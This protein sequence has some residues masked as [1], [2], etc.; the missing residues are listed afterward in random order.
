VT[1]KA[2]YLSEKK[3]AL[4]DDVFTYVFV[5]KYNH[6][7][8]LDHLLGFLEFIIISSDQ[9]VSLG[10]ANIDRLWQMCVQLPNPYFDQT[11]FLKWI[12]KRKYRELDKEE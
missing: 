7:E 5:G 10:T 11:F 3:K 2:V 12:N 4:P 8:T 1:E 6:Q 9:K